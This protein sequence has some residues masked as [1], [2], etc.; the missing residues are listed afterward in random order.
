MAENPDEPG[1]ILTVT[2]PLGERDS[3]DPA[4][5]EVEKALQKDFNLRVSDCKFFENKRGETVFHHGPKVPFGFV[6]RGKH[7]KI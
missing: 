3:H 2:H 6:P 5:R 7:T 1:A 4:W